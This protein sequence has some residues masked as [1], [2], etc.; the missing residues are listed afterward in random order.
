MILKIYEQ[1]IS[2]IF[3]FIKYVLT[4]R[5]DEIGILD[6]RPSSIDPLNN[7]FH[8]AVRLNKKNIEKQFRNCKKKK[9]KRLKIKLLHKL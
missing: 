5:V 8:S 1:K 3:D 2:L 6:L 7:H 4:L 9:I